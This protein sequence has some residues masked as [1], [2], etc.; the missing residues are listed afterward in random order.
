MDRAE[1]QFPPLAGQIFHKAMQRTLDSGGSVLVAQGGS[2]YR[3][4]RDHEPEFLKK[5]E[6]PIRVERGRIFHALSCHSFRSSQLL[7]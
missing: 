6:P 7:C 3:I 2:I 5:I 1:A 4:S